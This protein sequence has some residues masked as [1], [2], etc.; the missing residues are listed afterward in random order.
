[1]C[2]YL[3]KKQP[4]LSLDISKAKAKALSRYFIDETWKKYEPCDRKLKKKLWQT[5][6]ECV[7]VC[8]WE[9][10]GGREMEIDMKEGRERENETIKKLG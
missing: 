1:M 10:G 7:C 5:K 9:R 8:V 2:L 3:S 4:S 6:K